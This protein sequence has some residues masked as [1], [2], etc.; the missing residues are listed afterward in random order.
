MF[1]SRREKEGFK[2]NFVLIAENLRKTVTILE[3]SVEIHTE[4]STSIEELLDICR[5]QQ[6]VIES[7]TERVEKLEGGKTTGEVL[8]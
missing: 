2:T 7:L 1:I 8:P 5:I 4:Q 6:D 3:N